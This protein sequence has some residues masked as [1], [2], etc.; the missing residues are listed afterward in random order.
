MVVEKKC[1][2]KIVKEVVKINF[3]MEINILCE[4]LK[5]DIDKI[6]NFIENLWVVVL[7]IGSGFFFVFY[8]DEEIGNGVLYLILERIRNFVKVIN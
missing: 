1:V 7:E 4:F 6:I 5:V 8:D 3:D 2:N